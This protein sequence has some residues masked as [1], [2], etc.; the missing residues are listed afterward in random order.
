MLKWA[1]GC[2]AAGWN[3]IQTT[4]IWIWWEEENSLLKKKRK[5]KNTHS[6]TH[7]LLL[8]SKWLSTFDSFSTCYCFQILVISLCSSRQRLSYPLWNIICHLLIYF[9]QYNL[10]VHW[11]MSLRNSWFSDAW[12]TIRSYKSQG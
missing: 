8:I 5:E 6:Y 3:K 11:R 12:C 4:H 2:R 10:P 7:H 9:P 1:H